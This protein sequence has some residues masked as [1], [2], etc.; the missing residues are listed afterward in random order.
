MEWTWHCRSTEGAIGS[1]GV[2]TATPTD[3]AYRSQ[4]CNVRPFL[5]W[6]SIQRLRK[7]GKSSLASALPLSDCWPFCELGVTTN[8]FLPFTSSRSCTEGWKI[9]PPAFLPHAC[10]SKARQEAVGTFQF[11]SQKEC[12][13]T[14]DVQEVFASAHDNSK[15]AILTRKNPEGRATCVLFNEFWEF[16][17]WIFTV[18][19]N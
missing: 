15:V 8:V 16:T 2:I 19:L 10:L 6:Q 7:P 11:F 12:P 13:P 18:D 4:K 14:T 9:L 5:N 1:S 17:S 3:S